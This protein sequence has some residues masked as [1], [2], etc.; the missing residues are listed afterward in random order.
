MSVER[1]IMAARLPPPA[2]PDFNALKA[3]QRA[4]RE[5]FP[6]SLSLR[7]HRAISWLGRAEDETDDAD[8]RFILLWIGFNAAYACDLSMEAASERDTFQVYF[9]ALVELDTGYRIYDAIW[10]RFSHEI[11]LL[12]NN[13]YVFAPFW[14]HNN[15]VE[16]YDDWAQRLAESQRRINS[17]MKRQDT[18]R[19]LSILFGRLY[20]V[21]NQLIHGGA[22]WNSGVNR[23]QVRNGAAVMSWLLPVFIDIMM[24]NP[25]RDWGRPYYPVVE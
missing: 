7:V 5:G 15:G 14:L 24:E 20:V 13:K 6:D 19:I 8:V 25:S 23:D 17:A 11:R 1:F 21:R 18:A 2:K 4:L 12:L 10:V 16:G 9:D 3:K 22:T